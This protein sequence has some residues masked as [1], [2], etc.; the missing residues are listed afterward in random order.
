MLLIGTGI[1]FALRSYQENLPV[2]KAL[3]D[4]EELELAYS[5]AVKELE[6][7][8]N[9]DFGN[10]DILK[11]NLK[12]V[13]KDIK[14]EK[15][16]ITNNR[17]TAGLNLE[18]D[19]AQAQDYRDKLEMS[20]QVADAIL[21]QR[22]AEVELENQELIEQNE[23]L[24][25]QTEEYEG[26]LVLMKE[27]FEEEKTNNT[28]LRETVT[29]ISEKIESLEKEGGKAQQEIQ[30]LVKA[31]KTYEK[32]LTQSTM[33]IEEQNNKISDYII[34]LRKANVNCYFVYEEG[35]VDNEA[36]IYLTE[37]GIS[38]RYL[39][40]FLKKK[41]NIVIEFLL[42]QELFTDGAEKVELIIT[43]DNEDEVYSAEKSIS[44]SDLKVSVPAKYFTG[45]S[46]YIMLKQGSEDL[47][48]NGEYEIL[49]DIL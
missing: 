35:N 16:R 43:N 26:E 44:T 41:P 12:N 31:K 29:S 40:Y 27:S 38:K 48:I 15:E 45:G 6:E 28:Q 36:K 39:R 19:T 42:N 17:R 18:I 49:L 11:Q 5:T 22:L 34:D 32:R 10:I 24:V 25:E 14:Q 8:S 23:V 9:N 3:R 2:E 30:E 46:Y 47:L 21:L 20:K 7:V 33:V 13:L 37:N 4:Y 1:F